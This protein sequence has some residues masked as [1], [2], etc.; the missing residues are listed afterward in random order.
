M[1][2]LYRSWS[3][4][5]TGLL[6]TGNIQVDRR[7]MERPGNVAID[8]TQT[9]E[10]LSRLRAFAKAGTTAG[11]HCWAQ[12]G[13]AGRQCDVKVNKI[14]VGPSAIQSNNLGGY[15]SLMPS[16][17]PK[18]LTVTEID[19]VVHRFAFAAMICKASGFTGVQIHAAH[20]FLLSSFLNPSA[21]RRTDQY[22]GSLE[23]RVRLLLSVVKEVRGVVGEDFPVGVKLNSSDFQ[24]GSFSHE[25]AM[26]VARLLD[27][28]GVDLLEISGGNFENPALLGGENVMNSTHVREAYFLDYAKGIQK[29]VSRMVLCLT[30]GMRS[31]VVMEN[32]IRESSIQVI[33]VGRPLCAMPDATKRI[34]SRELDGFPRYEND[35]DLPLALRFLKLFQIGKII[36]TSAIQMWYYRNEILLGQAMQSDCSGTQYGVLSSYFFLDRWDQNQ[37]KRLKNLDCEGTVH[38]AT[39][40]KMWLYVTICIVCLV[41]AVLLLVQITCK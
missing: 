4:G 30:G 36:R 12:I 35:L 18:E 37:A 20:G 32:V 25:D 15:R 10:Q 40:S 14:G 34:F 9:D 6:I 13:H 39:R 22:G 11:N 16:W 28:T 5:G 27:A 19:D 8:G 38:N 31:R 33:G 26:E 1:G 7:Y 29:H 17:A 23:N 2:E 24:K 41:G 3:L 21:N